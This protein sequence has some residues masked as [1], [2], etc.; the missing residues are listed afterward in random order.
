MRR[1]VPGFAVCTYVALA[2]SSPAQAEER[3]PPPIPREAQIAKSVSRDL[4]HHE[5]HAYADKAFG[6]DSDTGMSFAQAIG[7]QFCDYQ[8]HVVINYNYAGVK[9]WAYFEA[10]SWCGNGSVVTYNSRSAWGEVY[11]LWR[12]LTPCKDPSHC[13]TET[14]HLGG[15][16]QTFTYWYAKGH[17]CFDVPGWSC[18]QSAYPWV[19][20]KGTGNDGFYGAGDLGM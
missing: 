16:Y 11:H 18:V 13:F 12:D 6:P 10:L 9:L 1:L 3:T 5:L 4:S 19:V 15:D 7:V 14:M 17:F 2:L 8:G 20:V